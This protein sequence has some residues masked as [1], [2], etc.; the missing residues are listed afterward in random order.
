MFNTTAA[1]ME[2][3]K[4]LFASGL[5]CGKCLSAWVPSFMA[6]MEMVI[7]KDQKPLQ[8]TNLIG[9]TLM[10]NNS[11]CHT[12]FIARNSAA[13][14]AKRS[15]SREAVFSPRTQK[16]L[17]LQTNTTEKAVRKSKVR[18]LLQSSSKKVNIGEHEDT[19]DTKATPPWRSAVLLVSNE[20]PL[21]TEIGSTSHASLSLG[22]SKEAA[23]NEVHN[24]CNAVMESGY[25]KPAFMVSLTHIFTKERHAK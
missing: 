23:A 7:Q 13:M 12:L 18:L 5:A 8:K 9:D 15:A 21:T 14:L 2:Q 1:P 10:V 22:R 16:A 24:I 20:A 25:C 19:M 11:C 6:T 17:P 3:R 4:A